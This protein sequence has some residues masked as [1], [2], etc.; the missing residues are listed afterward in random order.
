MAPSMARIW[1]NTFRRSMCFLSLSAY[2]MG[3]KPKPISS[4]ILLSVAAAGEFEPAIEGCM[5]RVSR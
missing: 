4:F 2:Q 5:N 1:V 3:L